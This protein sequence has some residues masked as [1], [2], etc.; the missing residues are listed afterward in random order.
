MLGFL[1]GISSCNYW[2]DEDADEWGE[3]E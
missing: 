2:G 3:E 1:D